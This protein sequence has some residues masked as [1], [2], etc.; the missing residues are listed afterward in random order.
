VTDEVTRD[1]QGN[2]RDVVLV[3]ESRTR[4][5]RKPEL[6]RETMEFK[7]FRLTRTKTEHMRYD[8]D[9]NT[10]EEGDVSLEC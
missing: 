5:N 3:D 1:I 7:G 6:W 4:V 9:T 10:H 2:I 8:F